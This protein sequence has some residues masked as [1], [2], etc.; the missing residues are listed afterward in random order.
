M[1][2]GGAAPVK[3]TDTGRG[4]LIQVVKDV[5]GQAII[6]NPDVRLLWGRLNLVFYRSYVGPAPLPLC[7]NRWL[8]SHLPR[9]PTAEP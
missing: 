1:P 3:R 8:I 7:W 5:M 4:R 2:F 6:V 9:T